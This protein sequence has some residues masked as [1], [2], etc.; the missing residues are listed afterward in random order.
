M[1]DKRKTKKG[2]S[3]SMISK[4][5]IAL[6][7]IALG[8]G[9]AMG[10]VP[11]SAETI[12]YLL[13]APLSLPAFGPPPVRHGSGPY[14]QVRL[15][16]LAACGT[17]GLLDAA[18]RGRCAAR[19][20]EQDLARTIAGRGAVGPGMLVIADLNFCG[21]PVA[22]CL[23]AAG[24]DLLIRAKASQNLPV[25]EAL[26]DG[27]YRSVLPDPAA[28][29]TW[30]HRNGQRRRRGSHLPPSPRPVLPG[31][32]IRVIEA[33][34]TITPAG[35]PPRTEHCRL[36][37]T[38]TDPQQAPAAGLAAVYAQRWEIENSYREIKTFTLGPSRVLR[39]RTPATITQEI[40]A[41]LCA[42]QLIHTTRT[43]AAASRQKLDPDRIS[44][45][46][47]LRALRRAITTNLSPH[48]THT[49]TLTQLLPPRR[50]RSYPRLRYTS[51]THR[52]HARAHLTGTTT[53]K[54]TITTPTQATGLPAP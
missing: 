47:T 24:A 14:P 53:Y 46:I 8:V 49:E 12:T 38:V 50:P 6:A 18:F 30:A 28:V 20:S 2:A 19:S 52:R 17:R 42:C 7:G 10:A 11:A 23:A 40:W 1:R 9:V 16:T 35:Q 21:Y 44:Y 29:R 22:A 48:A 26:P 54:I 34:I 43:Q 45:T 25:H 32:A 37:T 5:R 3:M 31:I 36:I 41:L 33:Q 51:T 27:S 39:S 4:M 15:V 13:P